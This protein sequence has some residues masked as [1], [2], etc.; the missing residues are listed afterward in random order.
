M[1][2]A[3]ECTKRA[4]SC[5][6]NEVKHKGKDARSRPEAAEGNNGLNTGA[7]SSRS[8]AHSSELDIGNM[9]VICLCAELIGV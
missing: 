2:N 4:L 8:Y 7:R 3:R 9:R 5:A 1:I 6:L